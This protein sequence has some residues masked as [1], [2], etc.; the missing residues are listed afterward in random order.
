MSSPRMIALFMT[1]LLGFGQAASAQNW[2]ARPVR[3]IVPFPPGGSTD[4]V[5]RYVA[6]HLAETLKSPFVIENRGGAGG[7][8]GADAV[9][10]AAPDGH[11]FLFGT[12]G[13]LASAKYM[14]AKLPF[15][16]QKDFAPVVLVAEVPIAVIVNAR[17]QATDLRSLLDMAR[18]KP[19]QLAYATPGP[20]TTGHIGGEWLK[21]LAGVDI[22]HVPY[23]G[24]GPATNDLVA[25]Q[26]PVAIDSLVSYMPHIRNREL[27]V[28]AV[29]TRERFRG[30]PDVPTAREQ[31]VD[32]EISLWFAIAA[33]AG[34]AR[35]IIARLNREV[36]AYVKQPSFARQLEALAAQPLGGTVEDAQRYLAAEAARWKKMIESTGITVN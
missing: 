10:K 13:P 22:T 35:D 12:T 26:V 4:I 28:L 19:G 6:T 25:N 11:T 8:I 31:G 14:N 27:R 5:A 29:A 16:P 18:S 15:D 36:D 20:A 9:A 30:L 2:P 32:M 23:R 24:S 21:K 33:P 7:N 1:A 3:I 17:I 34:T